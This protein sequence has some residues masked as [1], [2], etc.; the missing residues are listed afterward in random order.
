MKQVKAVIFDM[1]GVVLDNNRWHLESWIQ[2][3]A[4]RHIPL[5]REEAYSRVFGKTNRE[6]IIS[7]YPDSPEEQILDWSREKERLY[8]E[9]FTPH[10]CLA[11][12]LAELLEFLS[13]KGIKMALASNAPRENVDFALDKGEIRHFFEQVLFEGMA[14]RPKP[15]P[16]IYLKTAALLG[17]E[18]EDCIVIEDSPTGIQAGIQAGCRVVALSSTFSKKDLQLLTPEVVDSLSEIVTMLQPQMSQS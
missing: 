11:G 7:A 5:R 3:A 9:L 4:Y 6:I 17:H 12:G 2:Y 15:F 1:D 14:E 8:R 16:D 10:F 18:P 13:I